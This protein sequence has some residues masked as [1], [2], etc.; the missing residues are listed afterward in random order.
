[1][2]RS[3]CKRN[4]LPRTLAAVVM[5]HTRSQRPLGIRRQGCSQFRQPDP[6]DFVPVAVGRRD[7]ARVDWPVRRIVLIR[8]RDHW[9]VD[10]RDAGRVEIRPVVQS[11]AR[12]LQ[13]CVRYA[14]DVW[15]AHTTLRQ[16][17]HHRPVGEP[18]HLRRWRLDSLSRPLIQVFPKGALDRRRV[19]RIEELLERCGSGVRR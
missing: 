2:R 16:R 7:I 15:K 8:R 10:R 6:R 19:Q 4:I 9:R 3:L 12:R 1:M 13:T 5:P 17:R 14:R 18:R 11:V